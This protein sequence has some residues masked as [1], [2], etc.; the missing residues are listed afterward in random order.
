M[1]TV[2][3]CQLADARHFLLDRSAAADRVGIQ[4]NTNSVRVE[5]IEEHFGLEDVLHRIGLYQVFCV[6]AKVPL[7]FVYNVILLAVVRA[8]GITV[9][10][11]FYVLDCANCV[12]GIHESLA[13][14]GYQIR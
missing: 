9:K 11:R 8:I 6:A 7:I 10:L 2:S 3:A 13:G 14:I 12:G 1:A 5:V 4:L